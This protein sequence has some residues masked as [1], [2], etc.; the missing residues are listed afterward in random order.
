[1]YDQ[2][3]QIGDFIYWCNR[4]H[5]FW[6]YLFKLSNVFLFIMGGSTRAQIVWGEWFTV[7]TMKALLPL[8]KLWSLIIYYIVE[9]FSKVIYLSHFQVTVPPVRQFS[10]SPS[11]SHAR[12]SED[13]NR[14]QDFPP[15]SFSQ[16]TPAWPTVWSSGLAQAVFGGHWTVVL[17]FI[18]HMRFQDRSQNLRLLI[19]IFQIAKTDECSAPTTSKK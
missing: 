16:Q 5:P 17:R 13:Q 2:K 15:C 1:M 6:K 11:H 4:T 9:S 8:K 12:S 19:L 7:Y 14:N 10:V 18:R 3:E